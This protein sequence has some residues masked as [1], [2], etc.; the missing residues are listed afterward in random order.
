MQEFACSGRDGFVRV[1][2][3]ARRLTLAGPDRLLAV[4]AAALTAASLYP[5]GELDLQIDHGDRGM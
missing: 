4:T 2:V 3:G 1:R 5:T